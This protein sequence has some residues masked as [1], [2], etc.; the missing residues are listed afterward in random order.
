MHEL[1]H[2]A[3]TQVEHLAP[4]TL[5][6]QMPGAYWQI[7]NE[8]A[9]CALKGIVDCLMVHDTTLQKAMPQGT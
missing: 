7:G 4:D 8:F 6:G 5:A 2:G 9:Q 3:V 1:E